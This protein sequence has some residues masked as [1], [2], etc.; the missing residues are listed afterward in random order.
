MISIDGTSLEME[1]MRG[2]PFMAKQRADLADMK[3]KR[4]E[5]TSLEVLLRVHAEMES[6]RLSDNS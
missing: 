2:R 4:R 1:E 6:R 5:E 3:V